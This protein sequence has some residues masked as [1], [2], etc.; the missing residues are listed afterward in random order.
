MPSLK[1]YSYGIAS[2]RKNRDYVLKLSY[3]IVFEAWFYFFQIQLE[4]I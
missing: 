2:D 3:E 4:K 1:S